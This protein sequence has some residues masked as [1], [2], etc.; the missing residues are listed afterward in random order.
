MR[1][2]FIPEKKLIEIKKNVIADAVNDN[3]VSNNGACPENDEYMIGSEGGANDYFHV[4]ESLMTESYNQFNLDEVGSLQYWVDNEY[5]YDEDTHKEWWNWYDSEEEYLRSCKNF[6]GEVYDTDGHQIGYF[7]GDADEIISMFGEDIGNEIVNGNGGWI[8]DID[9]RMANNGVDLNDVDSVNKAAKR[10]SKPS[11]ESA[12]L[13]TDGDTIYFHDHAQIQSVDGMTISRFLEL[14]NIRFGGGNVL[15]IELIKEPTVQ[16]KLRLKRMLSYADEVYL[17]IAKPN[18]S[19]YE[20]MYPDVIFGVNYREVNPDRII[21]D[22]FNYFEEGIRPLGEMKVDYKSVIEEATKK[23]V[24]SQLLKWAIKDRPSPSKHLVIICSNGYLEYFEKKSA[25]S[26]S[27][28]HLRRWLGNNNV[29][30]VDLDK[31]QLTE[32]I[33]SEVEAS[34]INLSSFKKQDEL[35]PKIWYGRKLNSKVRLKLLDIADDF[36]DFANINW[37]KRSGILLTGSI[38]GKN[39]SKYSDIDLHIV[40][41]FSKVDER[42]D[43][44][45][46]Y[47]N[48]KKNEWNNSHKNLKIYGFPVELYVEDINADTTSSNKYDLE[49][50]DWVK[51]SDEAISIGLNKYSIKSKSANIMTKIDDLQDECD[52]TDD[53]AKLREI[54][55][56][57]KKL[58]RKIK[59]MRKFGLNRSGEGDS[60][61]IIYKVLR[62]SGHLEKLWDLS[63][64]LYDKVNSLN[65][66]KESV[67][68]FSLAKN[69]FGITYDIRECGYILPD[70]SMLDF[71]GSHS[72]KKGGDSSY[73]K[74][75]R[76]VDHREI[77]EIG[78]SE[79]GNE[80]L[81]NID[82]SQFI[83]LGAIRV[84]VSKDYA[85]I[86]LYVKPTKEQTD[87]ISRIIRYAGGC[88]D[89][90]IGDGDESLSHGEYDDA[91]PRRVIANIF[92]YFDERIRLGINE[93]EKKHKRII[94]ES[95]ESKSIA[96][97]K[98][99]V[100]QRL[101]YNEQEADEF[102]R[103]K[104]RNDLPV[105]RT[106]QGGKFIL[107]VAR[108]FC[109]GELRTANDVGNLNSTLKIVASDAHINEYDRNLNNLSCQE[110]IQKFAKAMSDNLEAERGEVGQMVFDS[111]SDYEIVRID[112]FEQ[113]QEY[114]KYVSWCITHDGYM[115]NNYTSDGINQFYFCL[116]NG[117]ENVEEVPS[118]GCPLD[119]YGLS[120]IAVS[121]NENGMLNTC[122]CRWNH[123]N[124]GNDSIM[125][126]KQVSQVIGMNFFE[127]FKPNNKWK[128]LLTSVRQ[129]LANGENPKTVFD[130]V[131]FFEEGFAWVELNN[132]CNFI[133]QEGKFLSGQWFDHVSNFSEG[134][135]RVELNNKCNFINKEGI[136]LSDQWFNHVSNFVEGFAWV[137]INGKYNFINQ[138]GGLLSD[139]WFNCVGNFN[140][141]F[142]RV[143][144]NGKWF[145]IDTNGNLMLIESIDAKESINE[146]LDRNYNAPLY[147]YFKWAEKASDEEKVKDLCYNSP[148]AIEDFIEKHQ[149]I[150][151]F[152]DALEKYDEDDWYDEDV[153]DWFVNIL[154][155]YALLDDFIY[156]FQQDV[157]YIDWPSWIVMSSPRLVK[158]EWCIHFGEDSDS[159][160]RE[161]FT[162]GTDDLEK[163]GYTR[164]DASKMNLPGYNF[165]Y[166]AYY[167]R[168]NTDYGSEAVLFQT[169]GV[170][171]YHD[172]DCEHQVVFWGPYAKNFIPI[173]QAYGE[174]YVYGNKGQILYKSENIGDI[175]RWAMNNKE[176]YRKQIMTGHG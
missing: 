133:N 80:K 69:H 168:I 88:V 112:S 111:P 174:W 91:N 134:F 139:Q 172:G 151:E 15:R 144:L 35:A 131:G 32:N 102:I 163:L 130:G 152:E 103:I 66:G 76:G 7:G 64:T 30:F 11:G 34:D 106:P 55:K 121:V 65:E 54:G 18:K 62:R 10:L 75:R 20:K 63:S 124:G 155:Q 31:V 16:Q 39:W 38:C 47:F 6:D 171:I 165:A 82:M 89:V 135:A 68:Y 36:W 67:D 147:K 122:T 70:G 57:A 71:T 52:S 78:W 96:A 176:Q 166:P 143:K 142:A 93:A 105:L 46:E 154:S 22:I 79:D 53:E 137:Y 113:A 126:A 21:N 12:Y 41:D 5:G 150:D 116:K 146:Y 56:R 40:V 175:I 132:K 148:Y 108:M 145:R 9:D 98:K 115:F 44:V 81:F 23:V 45:Q 25:A 29:Y 87:I 13:L 4:N 94:V 92:R 60:L 169:S 157:S 170:E 107:G 17:D 48:L 49:K 136:L 173:K 149:E 127:V 140:D 77:Y 160:A 120:M 110:L 8:T 99:L 101:N 19:N 161:G 162:H 28:F 43:F 118:D 14:G 104:L 84:G 26:N 33:E 37:V 50:N 117:F 3:G 156:F 114:G 159:I 95:Q 128:D 58:Y 125:N 24:P 109:D 51:E 74:G 83:R 138:E 72:I 123:D 129:R 97:A 42:T 100:M 61:N 153:V 1:T 85:F 164:R 167:N 141:G 27:L 90:E 73:L 158:N 2:V 59:R 119:V 86:N